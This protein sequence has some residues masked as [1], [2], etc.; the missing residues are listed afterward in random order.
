MILCS[1][2]RRYPYSILCYCRLCLSR[3]EIP[4]GG[5]SSIEAEHPWL[6]AFSCLHHHLTLHPRHPLPPLENPSLSLL[7]FPWAC[8][9]EWFDQQGNLL[10]FAPGP[11]TNTASPSQ[12]AMEP[13]SPHAFPPSTHAT[14][15]PSSWKN[16]C[17]CSQME[18]SLSNSRRLVWVWHLVPITLFK[19]E[20]WK[21][22]W[23]LEW[24]GKAN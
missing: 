3:K 20:T 12:P 11:I 8:R 5:L 22:G 9:V 24:M 21:I 10:C 18:P 19:K 6:I 13:P 14:L 23:R 7:S 4:K 16:A 2:L 1:L 15:V 17:G